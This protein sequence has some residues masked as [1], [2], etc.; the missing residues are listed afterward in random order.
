MNKLRRLILCA[1]LSGQVTLNCASSYANP[2]DDRTLILYKEPSYR[3]TTYEL[4]RVFSRSYPQYFTGLN[5]IDPRIIDSLR[6]MSRFQG[7]ETTFLTHN[8]H[9]MDMTLTLRANIEAANIDPK[10]KRKFIHEIDYKIDTEDLTPFWLGSMHFRASVPKGR[11]SPNEIALFNHAINPEIFKGFFAD[12]SI[13]SDITTLYNISQF[14][15]DAEHINE[16]YYGL[17]RI[18][19]KLFDQTEE[20]VSR[21]FPC[22]IHYPLQGIGIIGIAPLISSLINDVFLIGF[23]DTP[24]HAH[25]G[26]LSPTGFAI[27]DEL[28]AQS[29]QRKYLVKLNILQKL[30]HFIRKGG[31]GTLFELF[32]EHEIQNYK[33]LMKTLETIYRAALTELLPQDEAKFK[34]VI[35]GF[36]MLMHEYQSFC[37]DSF[38]EKDL[39]EI[40]CSLTKDAC[41]FLFEDR[42]LSIE[43]AFKTDAL[44]GESPLSDQ[45]LIN[46][47]IEAFMNDANVVLPYTQAYEVNQSDFVVPSTL[48]KVNDPE[49]KRQVLEDPETEYRF[50]F[51]ETCIRAEIAPKNA[52][53]VILYCDLESGLWSTQFKFIP[54]EV[55][56]AMDRTELVSLVKEKVLS[57][58]SIWMYG[59]AFTDYQAIV[60]KQHEQDIALKTAEKEQTRKELKKSLISKV[61]LERSQF[62]IDV[63]ITLKTGETKRYS[64]PTKLQRWLNADDYLG[65]LQFTGHHIQVE[66]P[67]LEGLSTEA[68]EKAMGALFES[69]KEN[70]AQL[71]HE[72]GDFAVSVVTKDQRGGSLAAQYAEKLRTRQEVLTQRLAIAERIQAKKRKAIGL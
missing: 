5:L 54:K 49:F 23:P 26:D 37:S 13:N 29:D 70:L 67:D 64:A 3:P 72:F 15:E 46:W 63:M 20:E 61:W 6:F 4:E 60:N 65:L 57:D 38:K 68:Q 14:D 43:D 40:L 1:L 45:E 7:E 53:T 2:D 27:H 39:V 9:L 35:A 71:I 55:E 42:L 52:N 62:F 34:R 19:N 36:F 28:H 24:Q 56:S 51:G 16:K 69:M 48:G 22:Q 41:C 59:K 10:L 30:N 33:S 32:S 12:Q 8:P 21:Q 25:S 18:S 31:D 47:G 66:K 11:P 50:T 58:P 17:E 44:T